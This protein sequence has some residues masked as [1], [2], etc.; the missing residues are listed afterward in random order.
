VRKIREISGSLSRKGLNAGSP[1]FFFKKNDNIIDRY[2]Y[3]LSV[4]NPTM[5]M[6]NQKTQRLAG[7]TPEVK[8]IRLNKSPCGFLLKGKFVCISVALVLLAF[9]FASCFVD[10][11]FSA[12]NMRVELTN[13][14]L[15]EYIPIPVGGEKPKFESRAFPGFTVTAEWFETKTGYPMFPGDVFEPNGEYEAD[16]TIE[17]EPRLYYFSEDASFRYP[18]IKV[19]DQYDNTYYSNGSRRVVS[20]VYWPAIEGTRIIARKFS[21]DIEYNDSVVD[22]IRTMAGRNTATY[23]IEAE[24]T[25]EEINFGFNSSSDLGGGS[26]ELKYDANA[27]KDTS[28]TNSPREIVIDGGGLAITLK[29]SPVGKP[30]IIANG[31]TLTLRNISFKGLEHNDAPLIKVEGGGKLVLD[32]GVMLFDNN[33]TSGNGGGVVVVGSGS[34]VTMNFGADLSGLTANE[35]G[36]VWVSDGGKF[37]MSGGIIHKN[38][39]TQGGGVFVHG[40]NTQFAM[41]GGNIEENE[42]TFGGGGVYLDGGALFSIDTK[43]GNIEKNKAANFGGGVYI[44]GGSKFLMSSGKVGGNKVGNSVSGDGEGGG[45]YV[46]GECLFKMD[47]FATVSDN[48][49]GRLGGGVYVKGE[50]K[51]EYGTISGNAARNMGGGVY[52]NVSD[53]GGSD[54]GKFTMANGNIANNIVRSA[55]GRGGGVYV[56]GEFEMAG[57][58][59]HGSAI[60]PQSGAFPGF[61]ESDGSPRGAGVFI[62]GGSGAKFKKGLNA[63]IIGATTPNEDGWAEKGFQSYFF[64]EMEND[65]GIGVSEAYAHKELFPG[66]PKLGYAVYWDHGSEEASKFRNQTLVKGT[67]LSTDNLDAW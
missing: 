6:I 51:M 17:I 57:G 4:R 21:G 3:I 47:T 46:G 32:R 19:N 67:E 27:S 58:S 65:S 15:S 14:D 66:G 31:V 10:P 5:T 23:Q 42:A 16:I 56:A 45:V 54:L 43:G 35:G 49:S 12:P 61:E 11:G 30:L 50:F 64:K 25:G 39:A 55:T 22:L 37:I 34:E 40:G 24:D 44:M 1:L 8:T 26:L 52:V 13:Y 48:E 59:I 38:K 41:E 63:V 7:N 28:K 20:V 2:K 18:D 29:G 62:L 33:N 36:G 9:L 60:K 53:G